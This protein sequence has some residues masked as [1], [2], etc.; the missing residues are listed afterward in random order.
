MAEILILGKCIGQG[1]FWK[2]KN[3][4]IILL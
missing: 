2:G 1:N 3:I 4:I